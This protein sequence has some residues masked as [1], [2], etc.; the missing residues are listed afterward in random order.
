[1]EI[2]LQN[3]VSI[4]ESKVGEKRNKLLNRAIGK[5]VVFVDDDDVVSED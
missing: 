4:T 3:L 1:M 5:R 2:K